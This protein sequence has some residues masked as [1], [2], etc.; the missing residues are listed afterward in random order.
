M[1]VKRCDTCGAVRNY[2][3]A[4]IVREAKAWAKLIN[5]IG[6]DRI[7]ELIEAFAKLRWAPL[8]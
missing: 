6:F 8:P 4:A 7:D 1:A 5:R 2:E 3:H